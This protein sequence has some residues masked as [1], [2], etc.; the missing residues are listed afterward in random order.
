MVNGKVYSIMRIIG[1][2][3]NELAERESWSKSADMPFNMHIPGK[4]INKW[5]TTNEIEG[6]SRLLEG[7]RSKAVNDVINKL[8]ISASLNANI[9]KKYAY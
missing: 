7:K 9:L 2:I 4:D 6:P 8:T 3:C 5:E 1:N